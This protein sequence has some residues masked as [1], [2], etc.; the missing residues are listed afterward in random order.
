MNVND[1]L[2]EY[3]EYLEIEKGRSLLTIRNYKHYLEDFFDFAKI[4][5]PKE[6]SDDLIRKYRLYLN[7][8]QAKEGGELKRQ[9]QNYYLIAIR[10]FLKYLA[11]RSIESL[12][13]ER[14][15][16]A[17]TI[18]REIE[19]ISDEEL[20]RLLLAPQGNSLK[21]LRDKAILEVLFSTGLRVSEL[22]GLNREDI[23]FKRGEFSIRGKG[24]K[25]RLVFSVGISQ[26]NFEKIFR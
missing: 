2:K 16:L 12:P 3:L 9:T 14:I 23:D 6:I 7:R 13:S 20:E 15:E 25:V 4:S 26:A 18:T 10:G 22:T 1:L 11:K 19:L 17:K 8:K 24:D 21:D 5:K